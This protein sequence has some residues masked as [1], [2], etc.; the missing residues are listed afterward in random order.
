MVGGRIRNMPW[1]DHSLI[2]FSIHGPAGE[3]GYIRTMQRILDRVAV[4]R[5]HADLVL[6]GDFNVVSGI[7]SHRRQS[8]TRV[9]NATSSI[10]WPMSST[11]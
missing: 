3:S 2:V 11:W 4:F 5:G 6:G 8:E 1:S 9:L 10:V 7:G